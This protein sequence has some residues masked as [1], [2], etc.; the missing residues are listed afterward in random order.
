MWQAAEKVPTW[1]KNKHH[2]SHIKS[3][4]WRVFC[5]VVGVKVSAKHFPSRVLWCYFLCFGTEVRK[6]CCSSCSQKTVIAWYLQLICLRT[7][8]GNGIAN[9]TPKNSSTPTAKIHRINYTFHEKKGTRAKAEI[10]PLVLKR[11]FAIVDR[12]CQVGVTFLI[13]HWILIHVQ[14][15]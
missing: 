8:Q 7:L 6:Q 1:N 4:I 11:G 13:N 14:N 3:F 2:C 10:N 5:L 15:E 9:Q 12:L